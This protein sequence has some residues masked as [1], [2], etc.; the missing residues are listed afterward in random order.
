MFQPREKN[1]FSIVS[2]NIAVAPRRNISSE[3][4]RDRLLSTPIV[5]RPQVVAARVETFD[6]WETLPRS[7]DPPKHMLMSRSYSAQFFQA[8][9]MENIDL[10]HRRV[11]H[12]LDPQRASGREEDGV[13]VPRG[14][15]QV[16]L[17]TPVWSSRE[18]MGGFAK[19]RVSALHSFHDGAETIDGDL[20]D[21]AQRCGK[22]GS[23]QD[24]RLGPDAINAQNATESKDRNLVKHIVAP[25]IFV[26]D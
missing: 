26:M 13:G 15:F 17:K 10:L 20:L 4:K 16:I 5:G 2:P 7:K 8:R 11:F 6:H 9:F 25:E 23:R 1:W 21:G 12:I 19:S 22:L 24:R 3:W 18:G 14:D